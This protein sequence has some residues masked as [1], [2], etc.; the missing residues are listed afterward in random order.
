MNPKMDV[1]LIMFPLLSLVF[2]QMLKY[3]SQLP[4]HIEHD[5]IMGKLFLPSP[6]DPIPHFMHGVQLGRQTRHPSFTKLMQ[7]TYYVHLCLKFKSVD[8]GGS[9]HNQHFFFSFRPF[10]RNVLKVKKNRA[11]VFSQDI[12]EPL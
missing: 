1:P 12:A 9:T 11:L 6:T 7:L 3:K 10:C 2:T 4:F 8:N 5:P